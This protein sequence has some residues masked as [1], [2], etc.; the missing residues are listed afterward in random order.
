MEKTTLDGLMRGD[1]IIITGRLFPVEILEI[2]KDKD[3]IL[4]VGKKGAKAHLIKEKTG[5]IYEIYGRKKTLIENIEKVGNAIFLSNNKNSIKT[6]QKY[7][8]FQY[9]NMSK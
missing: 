6:W 9:K 4:V 3:N 2:N 1:L 5:K 7:R 8:I